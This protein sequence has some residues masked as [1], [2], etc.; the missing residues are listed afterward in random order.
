[1]TTR[2]ILAAIGNELASLGQSAADLVINV[3]S[4]M[5]D[6]AQAPRWDQVDE[7][8]DTVLPGERSDGMSFNLRFRR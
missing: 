2:Q 6:L 4:I 7:V 5:A 1:M 3:S 8:E